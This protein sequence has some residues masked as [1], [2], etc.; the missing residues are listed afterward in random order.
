MLSGLPHLPD[1]VEDAVRD[2]SRR[3][4]WDRRFVSLAAE[5]A[6]WSK[7]PSTKVGAVIVNPDHTIVALGFNGFPRGV[8]DTDARLRDREV[9]LSIT[10]HAELN[11]ILSSNAPVR[12]CTIYVTQPCCAQCAAHVVQAGISRVVWPEPDQLF[13][14]RWAN[15]IRLACVI[16]D[17]AGVAYE[18]AR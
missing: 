4:K 2:S 13:V 17:E 16:F 15:S 12:G 10:I 8:A 5:V 18:V 6:S 3:S 14:E 11:A 9:K 1:I 7:D